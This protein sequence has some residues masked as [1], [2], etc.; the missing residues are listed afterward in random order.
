M[1]R[2]LI[3]CYF[4]PPAG[5]PGV[6]RWLKFVKYF[7]DF[8]VE[9]VLYIPK[10]PNYPVTDTSLSEE[11]PKGLEVLQ[12][13][14]REPYKYAQLFSKK[15]TQKM[16]SGI[17]EEKNPSALEK[18]ML[19]ARGN[20]FIPDARVGWVRPSVAFLKNYLFWTQLKVSYA[21]KI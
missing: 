3:I 8:G 11:I 20:L 12:K 15:K 14:I 9:P 1:K 7:R 13:K 21:K 5:G 18:L 6:Q 16:S 2:V 17:I 10:N 19:F 4:W